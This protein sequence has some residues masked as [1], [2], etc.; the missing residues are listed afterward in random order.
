MDRQ[1]DSFL[2]SEG[3]WRA[4]V[5]GVMFHGDLVIPDVL[6][7]N[8]QTLGNLVGDDTPNTPNKEFIAYGF[9]TGAIIPSFRY[10]CGGSFVEN[11]KA[12]Q[13]EG[14]EIDP[15]GPATA[16][17]LEKAVRGVEGRYRI[18][19]D[20]PL[21]VGYKSMLERTLLAESL[22]SGSPDMEEFWENTRD[23]RAM[24]L[25]STVP[26]S[27][28]GL[29]RGDIWKNLIK[30]LHAEEASRYEARS[31]RAAV[32]DVKDKRLRIIAQRFL[33]WLDYSYQFNQAVNLDL[34]PSLLS[35]DELDSEFSRY[36]AAI[37]VDSDPAKR[38]SQSF[39]LPSPDALMTIDP[40]ALFELRSRLGNDYFGAVAAWQKHQSPET[41]NVLLDKLHA[42]SK[43]LV[44]LYLAHGRSVTNWMWH[45]HAIIPAE[46]SCTSWRVVG[47]DAVVEAVMQILGSLIPGIS[48]CTL[49]GKLA[50]ACYHSLPPAPGEMLAKL[51][52]VGKR[53]EFEAE[54][55]LSRTIVHLRE[56]QANSDATFL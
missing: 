33:K 29:R 12:I 34:H 44:S 32:D 30:F 15:R 55:K 6:L 13:G 23:M 36:L 3:F 56:S 1:M 18:W 19:P 38:V 21:S 5:H 26:D 43:G 40:A 31:V 35:M 51:V 14:I 37:P 11:L 7:Y 9:R 22:S 10:E 24:V 2:D 28:G 45:L 46:K 17:F 41:A 8:S 25:E 27:R 42:Y 47:G 50:A 48:A 54:P 16:E 39:Q 49:F 52:G 53:L 20:K 4:L